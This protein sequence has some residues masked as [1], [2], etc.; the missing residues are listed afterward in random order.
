MISQH[1]LFTILLSL[2]LLMHHVDSIAFVS[3][4]NAGEILLVSIDEGCYTFPDGVFSGTYLYAIEAGSITLST[5]TTC[6]DT[7]KYYA[8]AS[9]WESFGSDTVRSYQYLGTATKRASVEDGGRFINT[10]HAREARDAPDDSMQGMR[11]LLTIYTFQVSVQSSQSGAN[12]F[13]WDDIKNS[14]NELGTA[15][16]S[17][18]QELVV[19]TDSAISYSVPNPSA[20]YQSWISGN[21]IRAAVRRAGNWVIDTGVN[22]FAFQIQEMNGD[23]VVNIVLSSSSKK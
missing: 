20:G 12:T 8:G 14:A 21:L 7:W 16:T 22:Y 2:F 9:G 11:I 23:A 1:I 4:Y 18:E 10:T 15:W 5:G 19:L 17:G 3:V 13:N 6:S